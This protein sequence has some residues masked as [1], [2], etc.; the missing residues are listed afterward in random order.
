M[1]KGRLG[2]RDASGVV[3]VK[4]LLFR[5]AQGITQKIGVGQELHVAIARGLCISVS[6][7][8]S[9]LGR[10]SVRR[11]ALR[12]KRGKEPVGA[13]TALKRRPS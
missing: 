12:S 11:L 10:L 4:Q 9:A 7:E 8:N 6:H 3:H 13:S 2:L 1:E 5:I